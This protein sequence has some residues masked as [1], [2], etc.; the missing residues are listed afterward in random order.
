MSRYL[1][2]PLDL[3]KIKTYPLASRPSKVTVND[4]AKPVGADSSL[5]DFL[6]G[7]PNILAAGELA[8]LAKLISEAKRRGRAIIAGLGGHVV[9]TG[10][11]PVLIDLMER[12]FVTAFAMNGSAMIHDFEI[13]LAGATSEDVDAVLGS[14]QFGMAE[15]TGRIINEAARSG[16]ADHI[17][18]GEAIGRELDRVNPPH[19]QSSLL[20]SAY[21][22]GVPVTVHVAIGTDIVHIHPNADGAAT[23]DATL[24]D[25]RLLCSLVRGLS[26]GGAYLNLGSAVVLPEVFLKTVTVVRNLGFALEGFATANFDFI[27]QYRPLTNVVRR[28]VAGTGRG[29]AFTGHHEIMIPLLAALIATSD[30]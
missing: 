27:Q 12:G 5:K 7:L 2:K 29:F 18:M 22:A 17:G 1:E 8:E 15:E 16:S 30:E 21:R 25:F 10:L 14:G 13:A 4:F 23:G 24:T 11:S 3:S 28:P 6:A 19:A 20:W 26:D 9:K